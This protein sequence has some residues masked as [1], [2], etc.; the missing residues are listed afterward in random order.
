MMQS[1]FTISR[2]IDI[3]IF[4]AVVHFVKKNVFKD[5][6][7][8]TKQDNRFDSGSPKQNDN[9]NFDVPVPKSTNSIQ[10][11]LDY[12]EPS[13]KRCKGCGGEIPLTMMKCS[14]CGK[15]Q[16]GINFAVNLF[17]IIVIIGVALAFANGDGHGI[18][19]FLH[20]LI[21]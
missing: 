2:I 4:L 19:N 6:K 8:A 18:S 16:L 17:A 7:Q 5:K 9:R 10:P 21:R 12:T 1:H 20:S 11:V 13:L 14:I 15:S 3:I